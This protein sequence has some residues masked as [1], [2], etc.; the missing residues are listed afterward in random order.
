M[1][2]CRRLGEP[3]RFDHPSPAALQD[4]ARRRR[5]GRQADP[6]R[7]LAAVEARLMARFSFKRTDGAEPPP[8]LVIEE[9]TDAPAAST[10]QA[11]EAPKL[12][13][14]GGSGDDEVDAPAPI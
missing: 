2:G 8:R 14:S 3:G 12:N 13:F 4:R 6:T 5:A 7:A 10:R 1:G 9:P 11:E